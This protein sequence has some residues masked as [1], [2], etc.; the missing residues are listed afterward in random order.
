MEGNWQK[1]ALTLFVKL[2]TA[3][4]EEDLKVRIPISNDDIEKGDGENEDLQQSSS[5]PQQSGDI[6]AL[7]RKS[8][9]EE[10]GAKGENH[11]NSDNVENL[12]EKDLESRYQKVVLQQ[13][14]IYYAMGM[15]LICQGGFS[16]CYHVCPTN[17]SLQFDTTIMYIM[18]ILG[19]VKIYQV[20]IHL[21]GK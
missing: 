1:N 6:E 21:Q 8:N 4:K 16:I 9:L 12:G 5:N 13:L 14:C 20:R 10:N 3:Q 17:H 7:H 18:C 19:I 2:V 11:L 15:A